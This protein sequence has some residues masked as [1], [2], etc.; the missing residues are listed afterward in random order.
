MI[1]LVVISNFALYYFLKIRHETRNL[2]LAYFFGSVFNITIIIHVHDTTFTKQQE[3]I[4]FRKGIN[5]NSLYCVQYII[6]EVKN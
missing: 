6:L 2:S 4:L 1:N 5:L 3:N